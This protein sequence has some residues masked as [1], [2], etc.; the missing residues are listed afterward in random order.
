MLW[1]SQAGTPEVV[2]SGRYDARAKTYRLEIVQTVPATP[3]QPVKEPMVI[4]LALGLVG[5][6]GRDLPL[7]LANGDSPERGVLCLTGPAESF[8]FENIEEAPVPSL[9]R[10]FSAPIKLVVNLSGDDLRSSR[11]MIAIR[12]TA[13]EALT[14]A[15]LLVDNV[16]AV[17]AGKALREDRGLLDALAAILDDASLEPAFVALALT[18]PGEADIA[19]IGRDVDP[20]PFIRRAPACVRPSAIISA[21]SCWRWRKLEDRGRP[22]VP[23]PSARSALAASSVS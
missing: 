17:R 13:G 7:K 8:V 12:S 6:D 18:M 22:I 21:R 23:T 9:N 16:A 11:R 10:G 20:T 19:L 4:P 14:L 1:Y 5:R 3:G 2:A 15:R